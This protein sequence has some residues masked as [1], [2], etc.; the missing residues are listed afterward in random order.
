MGE[1]GAAE[2]CVRGNVARFG[3]NHSETKYA[4]KL[5]ERTKSRASH[6]R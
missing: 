2:E 3:A 5:L 4:E 6:A 1:G